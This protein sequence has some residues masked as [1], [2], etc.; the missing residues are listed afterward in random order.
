MSND[1]IMLSYIEISFNC[2]TIDIVYIICVKFNKIYLHVKSLPVSSGEALV[3]K[4]VTDAYS[5]NYGRTNSPSERALTSTMN[6]IAV[7]HVIYIYIY[8]CDCLV[9]WTEVWSLD[10]FWCSLNYWVIY[11][12]RH[13]RTLLKLIDEPNWDNFTLPNR[14]FWH[15]FGRSPL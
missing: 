10:Y 3:P 13:I 5:Y 8:I 9:Y 6:N 7:A 4:I 15:M 1:I 12:I 11:S 14:Q 2:K